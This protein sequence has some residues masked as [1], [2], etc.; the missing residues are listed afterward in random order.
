MTYKYYKT[1]GWI[2]FC[3]QCNNLFPPVII[4]ASIFHVDNKDRKH[5]KM[6]LV[7][8]SMAGFCKGCC[9]D[10]DINDDKKVAYV[11]KAKIENKVLIVRK[12]NGVVVV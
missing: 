11:I 8:C 5:F 4:D 1:K 7:R 2:G 3:D 10:K 6:N 9:E 12:F